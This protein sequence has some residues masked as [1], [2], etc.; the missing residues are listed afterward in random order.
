[1]TMVRCCVIGKQQD[2]VHAIPSWSVPF[3]RALP[4]QGVMKVL[5]RNIFHLPTTVTILF[6]TTVL[7]QKLQCF[8]FMMK[9]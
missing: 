3:G 6:Y 1:M 4:A 5:M 2:S 9:C 7:T 8:I